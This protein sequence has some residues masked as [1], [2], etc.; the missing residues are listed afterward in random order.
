MQYKKLEQDNIRVGFGSEIKHMNNIGSDMTSAE[1]DQKT[2]N[3]TGTDAEKQVFG[4]IAN[5]INGD[6]ESNVFGFNSFLVTSIRR[7]N[8]RGAIHV[9]T[10]RINNDSVE[11]SGSANVAANTITESGRAFSVG[12]ATNSVLVPD[13]G[14]IVGGAV[15]IGDV[16]G[17]SEETTTTT[18]IYIRARNQEFNYSQNP[19]FYD[20]EGYVRFPEWVDNP[21][22]YITTIG[23]YNDEGDLLVVAK[24][25]KPFKKDFTTELLTKI[26]IQF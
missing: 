20:N 26:E 2:A 5:I 4:Q 1:V 15:N 23:L 22:V 19:S 3:K 8:F 14:I 13:V 16:V 12:G 25:P 9:P 6:S 21:V 10:F 11:S 17:C 24:L 7:N 18:Q